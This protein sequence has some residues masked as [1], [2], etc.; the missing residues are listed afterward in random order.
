MRYEVVALSLSTTWTFPVNI[1]KY[2]YE[3]LLTNVNTLST[4]LIGE[5]FTATSNFTMPACPELLAINSGVSP[6]CG[7]M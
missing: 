6:F 1:T 7:I 3:L 2:W 4:L 5:S